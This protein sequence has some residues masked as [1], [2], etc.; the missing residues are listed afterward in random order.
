[1]NPLIEFIAKVEA[2]IQMHSQFDEVGQTLV[3]E[4]Y[5]IPV[6]E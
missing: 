2:D 4:A 3:N 5:G 6:V 1:M